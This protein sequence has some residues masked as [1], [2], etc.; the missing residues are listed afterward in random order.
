MVPLPKYTKIAASKKKKKYSKATSIIWVAVV[1][2]VEWLKVT[3]SFPNLAYSLSKTLRLE[4]AE[5]SYHLI[6][7]HIRGPGDAFGYSLHYI[8][9]FAM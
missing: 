4:I 5:T 3:G 7:I 9:L 6:S 1:Q 2:V 8:F